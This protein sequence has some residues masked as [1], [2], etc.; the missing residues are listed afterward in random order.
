MESCVLGLGPVPRTDKLLVLP[1]APL[2]L[3]TAEQEAMGLSL[4]VGVLRALGTSVVF[5]SV[6]KLRWR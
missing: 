1:K 2:A 4:G 6:V 3:V 5:V